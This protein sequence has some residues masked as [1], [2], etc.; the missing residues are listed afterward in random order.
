MSSASTPDSRDVDMNAAEAFRESVRSASPTGPHLR[1]TLVTLVRREL[2]EHRMLWIAPVVVAALLIVSAFVATIRLPGIHEQADEHARAA[3]LQIYGALQWVTALPVLVA[4]IIA[5]N[6]YVLDCLWAERRD[7]SILFWKSLPVSDGATVASKLLVALL[8]VPVGVFVLTAASNLVILGVLSLRGVLRP[9]TGSMSQWDTMMWLR[10]EL[11]ILVTLLMSVLWYA[12]IAAYMALLSAW[13]RRAV[14]LWFLLPP[15]LLVYIEWYALNTHR[16]YSF[17]EYRTVGI[18]QIMHLGSA[19]ESAATLR[20]A[21]NSALAGDF[22]GLHLW[23]ALSNIDLWIGLAVA[24][25]FA[26]LAA[27]VRRFRDDT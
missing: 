16:L 23:P 4:M 26:W 3:H 22:A 7:R 6:F 21:E 10:Q 14:F 25:G 24:V 5:L 15:L 9:L 1:K 19:I 11:M 27:R 13:A 20:A 2:W 18:W 8:V 17:L 12:P